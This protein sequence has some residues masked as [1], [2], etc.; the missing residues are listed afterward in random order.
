MGSTITSPGTGLLGGM[1]AGLTDVGCVVLCTTRLRPQASSTSAAQSDC[2]GSCGTV[3]NVVWAVGGACA[4]VF[5]PPCSSSLPAAGSWLSCCSAAVMALLGSVAVAVVVVVVTTLRSHWVG[6][7]ADM[8]M[9]WGTFATR[10][11]PS[12][13]VV[14]NGSSL[15]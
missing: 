15:V 9:T 8:A 3:S 14:W 4:S 10:L 13:V 1:G 11:S 5:L 7:T 6:E 2:A 12:G